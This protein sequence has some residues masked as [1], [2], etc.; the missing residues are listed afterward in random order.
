MRFRVKSEV[1]GGTLGV[2]LRSGL[3]AHCFTHHAYIV[4]SE[5]LIPLSDTLPRISIA[6][7]HPAVE[8]TRAQKKVR[9]ISVVQP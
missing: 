4:T 7:G 5:V 8:F 6:V 1:Y 9:P 2:K 3:E